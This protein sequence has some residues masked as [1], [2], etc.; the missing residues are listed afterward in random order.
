MLSFITLH[1]LFN[2]ATF[3]LVYLTLP[4]WSHLL[5]IFSQGIVGWSLLTNPKPETQGGNI[6]NLDPIPVSVY[7][8]Y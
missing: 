8:G 3:D 7:V 4:I 2:M 5:K 6:T 1:V